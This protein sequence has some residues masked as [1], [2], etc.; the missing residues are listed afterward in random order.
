MFIGKGAT[1]IYRL[2][3]PPESTRHRLFQAGITAEF[4]KDP[5]VAQRHREQH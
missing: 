4:D 3:V 1:K 5:S 2:G